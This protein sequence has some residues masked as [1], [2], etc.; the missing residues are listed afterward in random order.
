MSSKTNLVFE[1]MS[2]FRFFLHLLLAHGHRIND[3]KDLS[4]IDRG[5]LPYLF[6]SILSNQN[7]RKPARGHREVPLQEKSLGGIEAVLV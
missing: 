4:Q 5:L 2:L 1:T 6:A 3:R 7:D